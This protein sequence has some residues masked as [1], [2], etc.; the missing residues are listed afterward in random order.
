[1]PAGPDDF[2][3]CHQH[4]GL[5]DKR[6]DKSFAW[7]AELQQGL[8]NNFG[9]KTF[10]ANQR[11]AINASLAGKDV[12]VLMPTGG[13]M[14]MLLIAKPWNLFLSVEYAGPNWLE[15][16]NCSSRNLAGAA[17][18]VLHASMKEWKMNVVGILQSF[19]CPR[20]IR[21]ALL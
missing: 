13:G 21:R 12:F 18:P 1:M 5:V 7:S 16:V 4:D 3:T 20:S 17:E 8:E 9:T 19:T 14:L 10:R 2:V 15:T 11:Q 6:W